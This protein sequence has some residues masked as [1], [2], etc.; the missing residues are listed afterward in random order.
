[1]VTAK[2]FCV[3]M[4]PP[5]RSYYNINILFESFIPYLSIDEIKIKKFNFYGIRENILRIDK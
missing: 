2:A 1:M 4:R 5:E 3:V